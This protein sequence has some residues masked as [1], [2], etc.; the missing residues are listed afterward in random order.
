MK[1]LAPEDQCQARYVGV[2]GVVW[3]CRNPVHPT[4]DTRGYAGTN[5]NMV[6]VKPVR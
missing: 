2:T 1:V 6:P 3:V 4:D 5:H